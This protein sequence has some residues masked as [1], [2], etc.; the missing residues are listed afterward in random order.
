MYARL[1]GSEGVGSEVSH[2][3]GTGCAL[4]RVASTEQSVIPVRHFLL[5]LVGLVCA[6]AWLVVLA[7]TDFNSLML[8]IG[9][10][11]VLVV[12]GRTH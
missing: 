12:T 1:V 8:S 11:G 4:P 2:T 9:L 10:L 3:R 6:I 5:A 7:A